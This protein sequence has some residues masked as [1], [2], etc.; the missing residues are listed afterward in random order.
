MKE[1]K[2]IAANYAVEKTNE[3]MSQ[4]VAQAFSD[5]YRMGYK[6]REDEIPVDLRDGKTEFIDL[7]L[8][9]G[10]L[11]SADYEKIDGKTI[12]QTYENAETMS[13]PTNEQCEELL[14]LCDWECEISS[15]SMRQVKKIIC[16]GPNGNLINF[17]VKGFITSEKIIHDMSDSAFWVKTVN[18]DGT[19]RNAVILS[20]RDEKGLRCRKLNKCIGEAF[21]GYK[22]P[23]R[24]VKN[25]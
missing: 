22:L 1:I 12:Y 9:S 3:M 21:M 23:I 8:P 4:I 5:G 10:T 15:G 11:W 14:E 19:G 25:K 13:I 17:Q 24:L 7:G 18:L 16:V 6:D 2:E 20:N